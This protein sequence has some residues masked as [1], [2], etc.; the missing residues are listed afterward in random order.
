MANLIGPTTHLSVHATL[1]ICGSLDGNGVHLLEDVMTGSAAMPLFED[2]LLLLLRGRGWLNVG[3][4][5]AV[6]HA[7]GG[8]DH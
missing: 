1:G 8:R 6:G 2:G 5:V 7:R 4:E 3:V